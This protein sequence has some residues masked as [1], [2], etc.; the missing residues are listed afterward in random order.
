M[1][2]LGSHGL[3]LGSAHLLEG[4]LVAQMTS[5]QGIRGADAGVD[6]ALLVTGYD[7]Q[8]LETLADT[9]LGQAQLEARGARG[10]SCGL[11]RTDHTRTAQEVG[12]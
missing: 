9:E 12:A 4:A 11:Y 8:S 1:L 7:Q 2:G 6:W 3:G 10:I 5:E